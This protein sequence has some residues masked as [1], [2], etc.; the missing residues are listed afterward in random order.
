MDQNISSYMINLRTKKW[1]WP[2]FR[3]YIDVSI[4]NTFQIYKKRDL[5]SR[6]IMLDL[7]SFRRSIFEI[8]FLLFCNK[9]AA[10]T[11]YKGNRSSEKVPEH[12]RTDKEQQ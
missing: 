7:L 4:N 6:E 2:L 1:C 5:Q 12:I 3:F 8:Y 10:S 9:E 11:L